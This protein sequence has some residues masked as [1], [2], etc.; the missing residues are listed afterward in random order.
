MQRHQLDFAHSQY[1]AT[2]FSQ[3]RALNNSTNWSSRFFPRLLVYAAVL[4][5]EEGSFF[6][7]LASSSG[8]HSTHTRAFSLV[9]ISHHHTASFRLR[10]PSTNLYLGRIKQIYR[11]QLTFLGT[12]SISHC[13]RFPI[14]LVSLI[15]R[16]QP[17]FFKPS[18]N[19]NL[20][21]KPGEL[22]KDR[23]PSQGY[24]FVHEKQPKAMAHKV[25]FGV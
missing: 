6:L 5:L 1:N 24:S 22:S 21:D 17:G 15:T 19:H 13:A 11:Q 16:H 4:T 7:L 9:Q 8:V 10:G 23:Q 14:R 18:Q 25:L 12:A 20:N 2:A 3:R